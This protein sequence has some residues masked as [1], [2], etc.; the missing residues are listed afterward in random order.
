MQFYVD[1]KAVYASF[2][3]ANTKCP[4]YPTDITEIGVVRNVSVSVTALGSEK[5]AQKIWPRPR[6]FSPSE[7]LEAPRYLWIVLSVWV[8]WH[9]VDW[10]VFIELGCELKRL[11]HLVS[12][13]MFA[14]S[15]LRKRSAVLPRRIIR[16]FNK[17]DHLR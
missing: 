7:N 17:L 13:L 8:C 4:L 9:R 3:P 10:N 11:C 12:L 15:S 16:L 6:C 14:Y 1:F 5:T 2:V